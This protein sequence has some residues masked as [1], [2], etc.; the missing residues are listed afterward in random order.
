MKF[1]GSMV[2]CFIWH[3]CRLRREGFILHEVQWLNGTV[4]HLAD[5]HISSLINVLCPLHLIPS[6]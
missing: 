6:A 1:N 4:L 3:F 5:G 2:Q